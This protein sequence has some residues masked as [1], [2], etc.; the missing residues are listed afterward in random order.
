MALSAAPNFQAS[1]LAHKPPAITAVL[2]ADVAG[3]TRLYDTLGDTQAK[4]MVDEYI[5]LLRAI[6][7]QD[8][9]NG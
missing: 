1:A 5:V 3:S 7:A 6:V 2:F 9:C 4:K 8:C